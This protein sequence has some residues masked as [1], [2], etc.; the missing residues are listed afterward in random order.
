MKHLFEGW[1]RYIKEAQAPKKLLKEFDNDD[2]DSLMDIEERF[3]VSY[4]IELESRDPIG[5]SGEERI[6]IDRAR[7]LLN[8]DY[9][10]EN[11][12]EGDADQALRY[13]PS[14]I[15]SEEDLASHFLD[16]EGITVGIRTGEN[17]LQALYA[18][19][20][21]ED[22]PDYLNTYNFYSNTY[23]WNTLEIFYE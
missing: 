19:I 2:R 6:D 8:E 16:E 14:G 17:H 9:F 10:Y 21:F 11:A 4:E 13:G 3:S 22:T 5:E 20:S 15:E 18:A 7:N 23:A 1:R 12:T